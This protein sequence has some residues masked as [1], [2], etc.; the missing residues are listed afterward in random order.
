[1]GGGISVESVVGHGSTFRFSLV[2]EQGHHEIKPAPKQHQSPPAGLPEMRVLLVED[3]PV[4]RTLAMALLDKLGQRVEVAENGRQAVDLVSTN[5]YDVILMDVQMPV[6]D[7]IAATREIRNLALPMQPRIVALTANAY[8]RD[9]ETCLAAGMD[10]FLSKPFRL[11]ELR[12]KLQQV[13][14]KPA[15]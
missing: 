9:R 1:M 12:D 4:N 13:A 5:S 8:S 11:Q 2:F 7:G 3:H 6:L 10:D 14:I 15:V